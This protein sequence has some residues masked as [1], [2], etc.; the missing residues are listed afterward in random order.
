MKVYSAIAHTLTD[1]GVDTIFGLIG[2]ANMYSIGEYRRL[3]KGRYIGAVDE[4]GACSMAVGYARVGGKVG[5]AT[6]THGPGAANT[7]NAVTE[8]ARTNT[9]FVLITGSTPR[10]R[11][12]IQDIDLKALFS[13]TGAEYYKV[14]RAEH[15]VNDLARAL[16]RAARTNSAIVLDIPYDICHEDVDYVPAEFISHPKQKFSPDDVSMDNALGRL[17][18]ANRPVILAGRGAVESGARDELI[19]LA[20]LLGAPLATTAAAKDFFHGEKYNLGI[21][22]D[23]GQPWAVDIIAK[24]DCIAAFGAA[25][26]NYTT[27]DGE[28]LAGKSVIQVDSAAG[29]IGRFNPVSCAVTAD[30]ATAAAAMVE[31]L[32]EAG[33]AATSFRDSQLTGGVLERDP[34]Q[35]FTDRSTDTELDVRTAM[36]TLDENLPADRVIVTDGGRFVPAP[37]GFLHASTARNFTHTYGWGSIGLGIATAVGAAVANPDA[38]TVC[39]AGDGGGMMGLIEFSTAVRHNIPLL[40]VVLN[41]SAYG[42]EYSKFE[43]TGFSP[44]NC[45]QSWP[46]FS[47]VARS[48]G[49]RGI[50]VRTEKELRDVVA[51]IGDLTDQLLIEIKADPS[52]DPMAP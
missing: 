21:M 35:Y 13:A 17:A 6:V 36:V 28:L 49:G 8:A 23:H 20:D 37:W 25:L 4:G 38:V 10:K 51:E 2:D 48:L 3:G 34:R 5:V 16:A 14:L 18:S 32:K 30:A 33:V 43:Q 15:V 26:N 7:V 45:F 12:H 27:V 19:E 40:V 24:S 31:Q 9:P 42:A 41:D 22:G 50:T 29:A 52:V 39:V 11:F 46:E 47:E 44:D 1:Y